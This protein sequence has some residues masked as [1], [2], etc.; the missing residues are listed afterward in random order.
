MLDLLSK[1]VFFK[2]KTSY[3]VL[4]TN[5]KVLGLDINNEDAKN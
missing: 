1:N 4:L 5:L 2:Y 3:F